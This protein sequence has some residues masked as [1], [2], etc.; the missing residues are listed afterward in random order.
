LFD[1]LFLF[2]L[3]LLSAPWLLLSFVFLHFFFFIS[4]QHQE[5]AVAREGGVTGLCLRTTAA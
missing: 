2:F 3:S 5:A 1:R 4:G